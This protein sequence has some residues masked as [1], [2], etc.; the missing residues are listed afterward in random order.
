MIRSEPRSTEASDDQS[1][2][3]PIGAMA[4]RFANG[5]RFT[6]LPHAHDRDQ[7][8]YA[9]SGPMRLQTKRDAM[10]VPPDR[11]VY[12]PAGIRHAE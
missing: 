11:A 6:M 9:I 3:Q 4:K 10:V 8:L 2:L 12:I 5:F 7:H 1:R